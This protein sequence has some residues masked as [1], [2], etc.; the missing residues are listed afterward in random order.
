VAQGDKL[1][2]RLL[3]GQADANIDFDDLRGLLRRL[4]F[5]ED[6]EGDHYLLRKPGIPDIINI[7]P[8][9]DG[10]AKPYQVRQIRKLLRTHG[11]TTI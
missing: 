1:L 4:G 3:S 10:K 11:L 8:Q 7:Q 9:R 2:R 6:I 5:D